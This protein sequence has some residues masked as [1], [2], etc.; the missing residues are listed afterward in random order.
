MEPPAADGTN[1][2]AH[3]WRVPCKLW[4]GTVGAIPTPLLEA[5]G[6]H[7]GLVG[8]QASSRLASYDPPA[9]PRVSVSALA[10]PGARPLT[11]NRGAPVR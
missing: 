9:A 3:H 2:E 7:L 4:H 1:A 11:R 10:S 6:A 8:L 5:V